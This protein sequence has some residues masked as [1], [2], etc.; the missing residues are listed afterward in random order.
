MLQ[1]LGHLGKDNVVTIKV[2]ALLVLSAA[3]LPAALARA[4]G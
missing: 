2:G 4:A 1:R 3:A